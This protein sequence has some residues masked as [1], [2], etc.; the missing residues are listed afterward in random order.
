VDTN[1]YKRNKK[2]PFFVKRFQ[3]EQPLN[4][5]N[6]HFRSQNQKKASHSE[7]TEGMKKGFSSHPNR[8]DKTRDSKKGNSEKNGEKIHGEGNANETKI[9]TK[10]LTNISALNY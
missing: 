4:C 7:N 5:Q 1:S 8:N 3:P 6:I 9:K 10:M 2:I